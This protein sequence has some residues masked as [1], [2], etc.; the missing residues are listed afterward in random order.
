M[1]LQPMWHKKGGGLTVMTDSIGLRIEDG[2]WSTLTLEAFPAQIAAV[3][4]RS[5]YA[6]QTEAQTQITMS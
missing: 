5:V 6:L 4:Q 1:L 2:D 3:T